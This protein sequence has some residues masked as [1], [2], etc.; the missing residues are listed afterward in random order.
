MGT[1]TPFVR[2]RINY[3]PQITSKCSSFSLS[4]PEL[5]PPLLDTLDSTQLPV[6]DTDWPL[7]LMAT[8]LPQSPLPHSLPQFWLPTNT[9]SQL[10]VLLKKPQSSKRSSN[11]QNNGDT[12]SNTKQFIT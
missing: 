11:Q 3:K 5:P 8:P 9:L 1:H 10:H 6:L 12:K 4:P 7:Q 2:C